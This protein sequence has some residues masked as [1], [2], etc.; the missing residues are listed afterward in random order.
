MKLF[1]L[2]FH[3]CHHAI[4]AKFVVC[5]VHLLKILIRIGWYLSQLHVLIM[6]L[7]QLNPKQQHCSP[8]ICI[9]VI[10]LAFQQPNY[11]SHKCC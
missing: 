4:A 3:F 6:V 2:I 9:P 11:V 8:T 1:N 10:L 7:D 5:L